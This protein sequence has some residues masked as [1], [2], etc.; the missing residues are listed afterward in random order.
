MFLVKY[1]SFVFFRKFKNIFRFEERICEMFWVYMVNGDGELVLIKALRNFYLAKWLK[2]VP[3][4][5]V[6][7]W[8]LKAASVVKAT[9]SGKDER[10]ARRC[11][12]RIIS[13]TGIVRRPRMLPVLGRVLI[14]VL[15]AD[16]TV[17]RVRSKISIEDLVPTRDGH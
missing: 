3:G 2:W 5:K 7:R 8:H 1:I 15:I 11:G 13:L 17:S 6:G 14:S 4:A 9:C 16:T 10:P 12:L